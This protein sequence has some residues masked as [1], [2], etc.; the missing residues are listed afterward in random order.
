MSISSLLH[1]LFTSLFGKGSLK[2]FILSFLEYYSLELHNFH[3]VFLRT[4][5]YNKALF[6]HST[7]SDFSLLFII[8][9]RIGGLGTRKIAL[10]ELKQCRIVCFQT[11]PVSYDYVLIETNISSKTFHYTFDYKSKI[12]GVNESGFLCAR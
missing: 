9:C 4:V 5:K 12:S 6:S 1:F 2:I 10:K 8:L 11:I 7:K 3:Q